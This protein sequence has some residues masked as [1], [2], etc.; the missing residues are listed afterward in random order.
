MKL[1]EAK[2]YLLTGTAS[3]AVAPIVGMAGMSAAN[4]ADLPVKAPPAPPPVAAPSWAGWY[5]GLNIGGGSERNYFNDIGTDA[6]RQTDVNTNHSGSFFTGGAQIGY[7]WQ[8]GNFVYGFEGDFSG[9]SK[10]S[11]THVKNQTTSVN[12]CTYGSH[13]SWIATLRGRLGITIGDGNTLLY[14]TGGLAIGHVSAQVDETYYSEPIIDYSSTRVGWA[15]GGGIERIIAPHWTIG[16]EALYTDLGS[17]T[18]T[19]PADGKCCT[20]IHDRVLIGRAKLNYKF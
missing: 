2:H 11:G 6:V 4:A 19:V 20:T 17:Y 1:S 3:I 16:L 13:V 14:G 12:C 10:S 8:N 5:I 7:N 15:A 18:K 9:L